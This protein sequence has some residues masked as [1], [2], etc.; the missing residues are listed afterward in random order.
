MELISSLQRDLLNTFS[1]VADSDQFYLIGGTALSYFFLHHRQSKDL[2]LFTSVADLILPM[3]YQLEE[4]LKSKGFEVQRSR[5]FHS[6]V[7]FVVGR[8]RTQT[9]IQM[10]QDSPFLLEPLVT[11]PEFPKL[12]VAS[13]RDIA[14]GKLLALFGRATLRD[15]IDIYVLTRQGKIGREQILQDARQKDP[16]FDLYWLGVAL[17]RIHEFN[18]KASDMLLLTQTIDLSELR[19]FFD[20]WRKEIINSLGSSP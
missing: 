13:L 20:D 2:D 18:E 8:E 6:F 15:F 9:V 14:A 4:K 10:A 12:R 3:S 7:E 19:K 16:G 17:K 11:F 1:D 5:S